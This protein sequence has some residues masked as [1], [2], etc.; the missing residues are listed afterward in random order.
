MCCTHTCSPMRR[1]PPWVR[2][3][4][5]GATWVCRAFWIWGGLIAR[6]VLDCNMRIS[7]YSATG[8][9]GFKNAAL[10][11]W[12]QCI[13]NG[14]TRACHFGA[15]PKAIPIPHHAHSLSAVPRPLFRCCQGPCTK[16]HT[17]GEGPPSAE[18]AA[19]GQW[20]GAIEPGHCQSRNRGRVRHARQHPERSTQ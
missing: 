15:V 9:S 8:S 10:N 19:I 20:P 18:S 1:R 2:W 12:A 6:M 17:Q 3:F 5:D 16:G 11:L 13:R 7:C 14:R 4:H